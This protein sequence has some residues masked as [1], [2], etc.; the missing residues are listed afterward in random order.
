MTLAPVGRS[1]GPTISVETRTSR[2]ARYDRTPLHVN[3]PSPV[4]LTLTVTGSVR[5]VIFVD[6]T[7]VFSS[8]APGLDSVAYAGPASARAINAAGTAA[9]TLTYLLQFMA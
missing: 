3:G 2:A 4:R 1:V 6:D 8:A 5:P 7:V 9:E